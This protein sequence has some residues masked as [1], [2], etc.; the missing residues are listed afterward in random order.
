M[1]SQEWAKIE[2]DAADRWSTADDVRYESA[3][4]RDKAPSLELRGIFAAISLRADLEVA[5]WRRRLEV[6]NS[7][8]D[9][10]TEMASKYR[11][12]ADQ[13]W[14]PVDLDPPEPPLPD[15]SVPP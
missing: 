8:L 9:Y 12:A 1:R 14:Q 7:W 15:D 3:C 13:P 2:S 6:Y 10:H 11:R 5:F 4:E